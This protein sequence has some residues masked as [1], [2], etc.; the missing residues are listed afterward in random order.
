MLNAM[1]AAGR[2]L[3]AVPQRAS[4]SWIRTASSQRP[5]ASGLCMALLQ[6]TSAQDSLN[7]TKVYQWQGEDLPA[8]FLYNNTYNAV[9]GYARDER[10]YAIIGSTMGTHII[11]VTSLRGSGDQRGE[12]GAPGRGP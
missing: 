4:A 2:W 5:I 10:E 7:V 1:L 3:L 8:S 11:D 9:W 12:A 6:L